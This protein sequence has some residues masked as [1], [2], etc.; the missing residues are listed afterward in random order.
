MSLFLKTLGVHIV[1]PTKIQLEGSNPFPWPVTVRYRGCS[2][3]REKDKTKIIFP[4]GQSAIV[5]SP[6]KRE[7]TLENINENT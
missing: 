7:I 5:K 3:I 1:S 4:G 2:V 6:D